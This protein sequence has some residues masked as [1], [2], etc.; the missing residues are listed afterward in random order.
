MGTE[1]R[2]VMWASRVP[3]KFGGEEHSGWLPA[4]AAPPKATPIV[5]A[6]IGFRIRET[7]GGYL[8]EWSPEEG[9][10]VPAEPPYAGDTW[11]QTLSDALDQAEVVF[12]LL[13]GTWQ[14]PR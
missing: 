5:H 6:A 12:G 11:H 1:G 10:S 7:A 14:R 4:G 2:L 3:I 13:P 9:E 8:L